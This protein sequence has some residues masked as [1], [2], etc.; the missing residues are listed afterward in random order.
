M[1]KLFTKA[2]LKY[3]QAVFTKTVSSDLSTLDLNNY[4]MVVFYSPLDVKSLQEN[5][6]NF[7]QGELKFATFG[8][9]TAKAVTDA[10]LQIEILAPTPECP[11]IAEALSQY[12]EKNK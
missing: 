1:F 7:E 8:P 10:G 4:Q 11:S 5:Y 6:P 3:Q 2:K 9:A 12:L